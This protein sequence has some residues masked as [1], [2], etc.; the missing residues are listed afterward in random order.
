[1]HPAAAIVGFCCVIWLGMKLRTRLA[2]VVVWLLG[3]QF[4]LGIAD[5]L[6]LAPTWIQMVHLLG[7]D[8]YWIALV[9]LAADAVWGRSEDLLVPAGIP[10]E[11]K[12]HRTQSTLGKAEAAPLSEA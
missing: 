5:V 1:M 10:S 12:A 7:A 9:C 8:L 11:A 4:V 6:L 3:L 2:W